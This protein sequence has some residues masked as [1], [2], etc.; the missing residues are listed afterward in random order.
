MSRRILFRTALLGALAVPFGARGA[1]AQQYIQQVQNQMRQHTT[2][3]YS[4]GYTALT[5]IVTGN[6]N[7]GSTNSHSLTLN[8]GRRY[9]I[10]GVCDNDCTDVDLKLYGPDGGL[11]A[12]DIDTDDY[13]TLQFTAPVSGNYRVDVIMATCNTQPCYYGVQL[14]GQGGQQAMNQPVPMN[15]PTPVPM[16]APVGIGPTQMGTIAFNQQVTGNLQPSDGRLDNKPSQAWAFQCSQGQTFQMDILSTWDNYAVVLDPFNNR[17]AQDDD[18]GEGLNARITHTCTQTGVYHLVVTTYT[19]STSTGTY[20]LQVQQLGNLN[21]PQPLMNQPQPI[22]PQ[23]MP[24][25]M[26]MAMPTPQAAP[27]A[28]MPTPTPA[29]MPITGSIPGPGQI[30]QVQ[31]GTNVQGRLETGDQRMNDGTFADVWQFQ[32]RAG[33]HIVIELRSE[34]FDTYLQ[35]LDAAGNRLAEDDDSLG[36]L[37]SKIEFNLP[38][39]GMYQ[40]VVNNFGDDRRAGIYTLSL[41]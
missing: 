37:D 6:L 14:F 23:P 41:R 39:N 9:V 22:N 32:G 2:S 16:A 4:N 5:E 19:A 27:G 11:I 28:T 3:V 30:G 20:T 36:D 38:A 24:T 40:I 18:T 1:H 35:L 10:V 21:Q 7:R 17:V 29:S 25:P 33:Q 31:V 13:P 34:E 15:Q 26:P 8:G 12:Q